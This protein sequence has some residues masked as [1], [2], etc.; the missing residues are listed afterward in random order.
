MC[1]SLD[2]ELIWG[3]HDIPT[4]NSYLGNIIQGRKEAI[5]AMLDL[6]EKY[7][8]HVTW[9]IVGGVMCE[10]KQEFLDNSPTETLYPNYDNNLLSPYR[11]IPNM[12]INKNEDYLFFGKEI[13]GQIISRKNQYI[14]SHTFS[15]YYCTETGQTVE[16]FE[17]DLSSATKIAEENGISIRSIVF[18]RNQINKEYLNACARHGIKTYRGIEENWIYGMKQ[19]LLQR[20][21]RFAD[22]YIPLTGDNSFIPAKTNGVLNVKGSRILHPYNKKLRAFEFLK[23][24]R[25]KRQMKSA[26]KKGEVFHLWWHPHN[27]G[28]DLKTNLEMLEMI[29][30]YFDELKQQYGFRS[31]AMEEIGDLYGEEAD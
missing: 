29:L 12:G 7:E 25:I 10:N 11:L 16:Q 19:S 22:C 23:I 13:V 2:T 15:H 26:A 3:M 20:I 24:E 18:P 5:P 4:V 30:K 27:F 14:G 8:M 1:I 31:L 9:A 6:F 17:A 21:L 28:S